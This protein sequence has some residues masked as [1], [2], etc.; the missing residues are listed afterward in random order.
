MIEEELTP[1][2]LLD[3]YLRLCRQYPIIALE[4]PF[5]EEDWPG[6]Q[7]I[8]E[9]F[10]KQITI[11]GDDLLVTNLQ[12]IKKAREKK[13]CNGLILKGNEN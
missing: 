6:F 11:I 4:D 5:S 12:R 2:K 13:A 10:G 9:S 8:T 7:E 3:F 1:K